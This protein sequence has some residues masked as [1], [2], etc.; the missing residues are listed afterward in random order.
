M[1]PSLQRLILFLTLQGLD[2]TDICT[3]KQ[4][5]INLR[6]S[7]LSFKPGTCAHIHTQKLRCGCTEPQIH[8]RPN[9]TFLTFLLSCNL[10]CRIC[11]VM[12]IFCCHGAY[13]SPSP[14][15]LESSK[16]KLNEKSGIS[17]IPHMKGAQKQAEIML[18]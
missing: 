18:C 10:F 5:V 7:L 9:V 2:I 6:H 4:M 12:V 3:Y 14:A 11:L 13:A 17:Y 15:P 1:K 8:K 16:L